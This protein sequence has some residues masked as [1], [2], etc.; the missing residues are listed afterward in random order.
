MFGASLAAKLGLPYA[1]ASH[2]AP[3]H[4]E[5][6]TTYYREHFQPSERFSKPYVIAGVNVTA[7]ENTQEAQEE[8]ERVCFNRV[9]AFAGRGK[10]LT[11]EQVEQIIS[12][13]QGQQILD[14]LKYSAVGTADE[15]AD[16]LDTFQK[17]AQADEL[18]V[19]LQSS[20]H[21]EVIK[22]MQLLAQGWE[23]NPARVAGTPS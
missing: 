21:E 6:A 14:M 2:F 11:D 19:S 15:V 12:S 20:S 8:Y 17:H 16:Y 13:Y 18:M 5:Q 4:L 23:L 10:H 9:K 7:A 1:F 22:N 3:Q